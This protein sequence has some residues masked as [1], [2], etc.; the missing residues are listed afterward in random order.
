MRANHFVH[1]TLWS[2]LLLVIPASGQWSKSTGWGGAG[3]GKRSIGARS[4]QLHVDGRRDFSGTLKGLSFYLLTL[5]HIPDTGE[6]ITWW[7]NQ[8]A[9][10]DKTDKFLL[11]S[12]EFNIQG[13]YDV[14]LKFLV[15]VCIL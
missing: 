12:G 8:D 9:L 7:N 15:P 1:F 4:E 5:G 14:D 6:T 10:K 13:G 2:S 3:N 11:V